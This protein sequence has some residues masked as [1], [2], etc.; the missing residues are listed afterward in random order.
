MGNTLTDTQL[1]QTLTRTYRILLIVTVGMLG[2]G[3]SAHRGAWTDPATE[4]LSVGSPSAAS[5]SS[6]YAH[7]LPTRT[8]HV[9]VR[10]FDPCAVLTYEQ[11]R[12]LVYDLGWAR[13]PLP[14][15]SRIHGGPDC[16]Y[17]SN[18]GTGPGG[19]NRDLSTSITFSFV[20]GV[21]VWI[22]DP[23]RPPKDPRAEEIDPDGKGVFHALVLPHPESLDNC[24]VVVDT[25]AS[26]ALEVSSGSASGN[27]VASVEPFCQEAVTV[28]TM[29][30]RTMLATT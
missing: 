20:E 25:S 5:P 3:C 14:G 30:L 13:G 15:R 1:R 26:Q 22:T 29:A 6:R 2:T 16:T 27:N 11:A 23:T 12:E 19:V 17:S 4:S 10:D 28:A 18:G 21:E 8:R 7:L 9:D 24:M